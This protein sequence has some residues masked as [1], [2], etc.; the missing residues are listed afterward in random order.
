MVQGCC[1]RICS[2]A[3]RDKDQ[4]SPFV[5]LSHSN[6]STSL[7][8]GLLFKFRDSFLYADLKKPHLPHPPPAAFFHLTVSSHTSF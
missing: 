1:Q 4:P 5:I 8:S 2:G 7:Y 3:E 6:S